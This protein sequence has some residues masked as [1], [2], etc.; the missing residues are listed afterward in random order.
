MRWERREHRAVISFLSHRVLRLRAE[1]QETISFFL[2]IGD[3]VIL[4]AHSAL[5]HTERRGGSDNVPSY[6]SKDILAAIKMQW[7]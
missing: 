6:S 5:R 7:I 2:G 3:S 1:L 4:L